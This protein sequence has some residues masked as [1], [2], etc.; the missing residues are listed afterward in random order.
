VCLAEGGLPSEAL[1]CGR[2]RGR[3]SQCFT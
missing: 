1:L 2:A 3:A